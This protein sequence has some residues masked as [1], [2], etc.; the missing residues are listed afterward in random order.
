M[1]NYSPEQN[2]SLATLLEEDIKLNTLQSTSIQSPPTIGDYY[3]SGESVAG[4]NIRQYWRAVSQRWWLVISIALVI[5]TLAAIY[6]TRLPNVYQANSVVQVDLE[7]F[8]S[9]IQKENSIVVSNPVNDPAYFNTQL[10]VVSS[11]SVLRRVVSELDLENN[12]NFLPAQTS[13]S[14]N[15]LLKLVGLGKKAEIIP[16]QPEILPAPQTK[17][18][19]VREDLAEINRLSPYVSALQEIIEVKNIPDT[20]LIE[21]S[22][23]HTDKETSAKI[24]NTI[25]DT[26]V[27]MNLEKKTETSG[28]T[29]DFLQKRIAEIQSRIRTGEEQLLNYGKN[30]QILSLD[31]SQNTVVDRLTSLNK[32]LVEAESER[33]LAETAYRA[34]TQPKAADALSESNTKSIS[35]MEGELAKLRQKRAA[36]SVRYTSEHPEMKAIEEQIP[37]LEKQIKDIRTQASSVLVTNLETRYRQALERERAVQTAFDAQRRQTLTQNEAAINYRI[38]QQ[39]IETNKA[40][41]N[42]LL[43]ESKANEVQRAGTQNN[44]HIVDY[45]TVP[46]ERIA[47]KR[48]QFVLI[49]LFVSL[50]IGVI[51]AFVLDYLNDAVSSVSDVE[52]VLRLPALGTIPFFVSKEPRRLLSVFGTSNGHRIKSLIKK[53]DA[54]SI[55]AE[56]YRQ[57]RTSLLLSTAGGAPR[58]M[59]IT[60]SLPSEGKSTTC[61]NLSLALSDAQSKVLI[62]D[63]DLRRPQIHKIFEMGNQKGLSSILSQETSEDEIFS[64]INMHE[65]S[66]VY[67]LPSGPRPPNPAELIGSKQMSRLLKILENRFTH[68]VIDSPPILSFTDSL[69][70]GVLVDGVMLVVT[71]GK[72]S[73]SLVLRSKQLLQNVGAKLIGVVLNKVSSRSDDHYYYYSYYGKYYKPDEDSEE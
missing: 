40:L 64:M 71:A 12:K 28:S 17:A 46:E 63:A 15:N 31:P 22:V 72:T 44:I 65:E 10:R 41:L 47:P 43:Q 18:S 23:T 34:A 9:G 7:N 55:S 24:A 52:N 21:I 73:Q 61:A 4:K 3:P 11:A 51:F 26:F 49:A 69:L 39:E 68:I 30:N 25:A 37:I 5:T 42:N 59:L 53:E 50:I 70:I 58:T 13:R 67:V 20:R 29:G 62:I 1:D 32:Q 6:I 38:I 33:I 66:N 2:K 16:D 60:S 19:N 56:S 45:A 27:T 48:Q 57:L 14:W 35:D 8:Q 54:N 36:L